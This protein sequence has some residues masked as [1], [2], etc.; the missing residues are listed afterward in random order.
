M[1]ALFTGALVL[2]AIGAFHCM[3]MC[4]P[5]ALAL[6]VVNDSPASRLLS[7]MLYNI[8]RCI[9]YASLGAMLGAI[10]QSLSL[11]GFQQ[12][13]SIVAGIIIL[14]LIVVPYG[15]M[16]LTISLPFFSKV[17]K[18]VGAL[19]GKKSYTGNFWIGILN[20][21][22]PCGLV[23]VALTT[24]IATGSFLHGAAFMTGFGLG[25]L[26]VMW[27]L[28]FFGS[29]IEPRKFIRLRKFYPILMFGMGTLLIL[30]GIG[31]DL[32]FMSPALHQQSAGSTVICH[33]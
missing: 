10:G 7:S 20:G 32:P 18:K 28:S 30:R 15:K 14:L 3:G 24:A 13:L 11:I 22:L 6:P 19:F 27:S 33:P 2:G 26:P 9:T 12:I 21:L 5:L 29:Y 25:T 16:N 4:G 23:Y 1:I 31:I 8:G 17:R